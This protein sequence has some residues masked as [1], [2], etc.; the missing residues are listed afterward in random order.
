MKRCN[1]CQEAKELTG[2]Y[3]NKH[4]RD[5]YLN[6]CKVC[7][8][9][10]NKDWKLGNKDKVK[11]SREAW[12]LKNT[13]RTKAYYKRYYSQNKEIIREREKLRRSKD[14]YKIYWADYC[15]NRRKQD[16]S[17]VLVGRLR[18]RVRD[19]IKGKSK[20]DT[21]LKLLGCSLDEFR[22]HLSRSSHLV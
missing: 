4:C 5:G 2:F 22:R 9:K 20:S 7:Q 15:R 3:R 11:K 18:A 17:Y 6:H 21:T 1:K 12:T 19:F 14:G 13:D 8:Y 16:I 10:L